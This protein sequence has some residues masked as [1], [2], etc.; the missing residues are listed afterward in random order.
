MFSGIVSSI[1]TIVEKSSEG[2]GYRLG[3]ES[4]LRVSHSAGV[5]K[6]DRENVG[7]GDSIAI[8]GICLTVDKIIQPDRFFVVC[9]YETWNKTAMYTLREGDQVHLE[10]ALAVGDRL[11]GHLVQGHVDGVAKVLRNN[12][13][14]ESWVLWIELPS[15]LMGYCAVKGSIT[16]NGVS[17]TINEIE[18]CALRVNIVPYTAL[19]TLL[20]RLMIGAEVNIEVDV[21]ARYVARLMGMRNEGLS[22]ARLQSLGYNPWPKGG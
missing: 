7:L 21:I 4:S 16:I 6:T 15:D 22:F 13:Q 20:A 19:E 14:G 3:I 10:R 1:G 12:E 8:N 17:L 18:G 2:R 11:D 9:G 5:G